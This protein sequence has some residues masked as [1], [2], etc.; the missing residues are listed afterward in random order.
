MKL[1][2]KSVLIAGG[3]SGIGQAFVIAYA[4]EDADITGVC[5]L[6]AVALLPCTSLDVAGS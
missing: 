2:L 3:H 1:T 5:L 4:I 6:K